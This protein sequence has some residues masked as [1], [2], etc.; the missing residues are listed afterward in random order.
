[1]NGGRRHRPLRRDEREE[2]IACVLLGKLKSTDT[3]R[4]VKRGLIT[5][6]GEDLDEREVHDPVTGELTEVYVTRVGVYAATPRGR[7]V[8]STWRQTYVQTGA[9][10][11][12]PQ[13]LMDAKVLEGERAMHLIAQGAERRLFTDD[14][15]VR[16]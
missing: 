11:Y 4:L 8:V 2:L 9:G 14:D 1:M 13:G 6:I 16:P 10:S 3:G 15:E 7:H 5:R 12:I